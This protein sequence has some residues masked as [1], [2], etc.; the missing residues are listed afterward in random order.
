[1][2]FLNVHS[3]VLIYML[4]SMSNIYLH[5]YIQQLL[6]NEIDVTTFKKEVIV[7]FNNEVYFNCRDLIYIYN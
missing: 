6:K 3:F 2:S 7:I 5:I 4:K 1:M